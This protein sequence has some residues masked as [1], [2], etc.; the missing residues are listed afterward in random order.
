M[1]VNMRFY[2][3]GEPMSLEEVNSE[4]GWRPPVF[5]IARAIEHYRKSKRTPFPDLM[6]TK[7]IYYENEVGEVMTDEG[8]DIQD[9]SFTEVTLCDLDGNELQIYEFQGLKKKMKLL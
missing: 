7:F 3:D 9:D 6:K 2:R 4:G 1:D 8:M 5:E